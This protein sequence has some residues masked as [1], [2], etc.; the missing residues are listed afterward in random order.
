MSSRGFSLSFCIARS[1]IGSLYWHATISSIEITYHTSAIILCNFLIVLFFAL[2]NYIP[3]LKGDV[4][5]NLQLNPE[6]FIAT[7]MQITRQDQYGEPHA[8]NGQHSTIILTGHPV[9]VN[10]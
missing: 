8:I 10:K 1:L 4:Y 9:R 5:V 6:R 3:G 2:F 7:A